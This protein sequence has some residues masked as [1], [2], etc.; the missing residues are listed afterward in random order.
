MLAKP[1]I[2][3][4]GKGSVTADTLPVT[5]KQAAEEGSSSGKCCWANL[6]L[7]TAKCPQQQR[8]QGCPRFRVQR[9]LWVRLRLGSQV[10]SFLGFL[11]E[12]STCFFSWLAVALFK[13]GDVSDMIPRSYISKNSFLP[14]S[15]TKV[16]S[17]YFKCLVHSLFLPPNPADTAVV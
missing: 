6:H 7:L 9:W 8:I 5:G 4:R 1:G 3:L 17:T 13:E 2:C 15:Y 14:P 16:S 10:L 11:I 12:L